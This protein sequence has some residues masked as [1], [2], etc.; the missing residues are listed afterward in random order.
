MGAGYICLRNIKLTSWSVRPTVKGTLIGAGL[1]AACGLAFDVLYSGYA[2]LSGADAAA[3]PEAPGHY[4]GGV[5]ASLAAYS[6]F[7]GFYE[8][9]FFSSS[10]CR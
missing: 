1:F 10:A 9:F 2:A 7:N 8:E 3:G 5:D 6:V 4:A